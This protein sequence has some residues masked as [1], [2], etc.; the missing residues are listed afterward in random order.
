MLC[1]SNCLLADQIDGNY[2]YNWLY[3]DFFTDFCLCRGLADGSI[4]FYVA[5]NPQEGPTMGGP[6]ADPPV[7]PPFYLDPYFG[8]SVRP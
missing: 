2:G 7:R 8:P 3:I 6:S 5:D 1:C 4:A